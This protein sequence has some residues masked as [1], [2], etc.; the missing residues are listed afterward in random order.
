MLEN[1]NQGH[2]GRGSG[3]ERGHTAVQKAVDFPLAYP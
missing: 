2:R 1:T 3:D